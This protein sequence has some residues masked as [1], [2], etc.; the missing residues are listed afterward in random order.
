MHIYNNVS[1]RSYNTF[2]IDVKAHCLVECE[3]V[4][5]VE[6]IARQSGDGRK[7]VLGGGS[8]VLLMSDFDGIVIC[9]KVKGCEIID[10]R[11]NEVIVRVGSGVVWDDFVAYAVAQG[12]YG[13][14][15][16]SGIPGNV[17]AS[18]VQNVG[19]YGMEA[20]QSIC[21]VEGYMMGTGERFALSGSDCRFGY[22]DSIFKH[23]LKGMAIVT[24]VDFKLYKDAPVQLGYGPVKAAVESMGGV[25]LQN[26][27]KAIIDIRN[28]KL[29]DPAVEGSAGS[30]FKNPEVDSSFANEIEQKNPNMPK[31]DLG[32][33]MVKIPAGWLIE[34]SG[35]KGRVLGKAG[36]HDKQAL[37]LVNKGGATGSDV[38]N[39]ANEVSKSVYEKF[40]IRL[41]MEVCRID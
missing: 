22:R 9:P 7:L 30:F 32:N 12:L 24:T 3:N 37:V 1:L 29:P 35:W 4:N 6:M 18:P 11:G 41:E 36:V 10:A 39:V 19:A 31:Y 21:R 27:R 2:G 13:V 14:E 26:V 38:M 25:T 16:L 15:N 40:G 5:D 33:G 28:S 17:G 34:Q 8:N 20:G 23:E